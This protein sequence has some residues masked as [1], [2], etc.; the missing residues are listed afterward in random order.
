M[1]IKPIKMVIAKNSELQSL[2]VPSPSKM[3]PSLTFLAYGSVFH[4]HPLFSF[5]QQYCLFAGDHCNF[6]QW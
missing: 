2:L 5:L 6:K 3:H 4:L 1:P